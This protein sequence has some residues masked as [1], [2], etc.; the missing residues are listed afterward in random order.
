[1]PST[2]L[3]TGCS[4]GIGA[5]AVQCFAAHGWNVAA[6]LRKLAQARLDQGSGCVEQFALDVTDQASVD[7]AVAQASERFGRIDVLIN[8]AGYG[9]FGPFETAT[10]ELIRRQFATNVEGVFAV[11]RAVLP[12]MRA[13]GSGVIINIASLTGLVAMPL[14][15]LYA[16]SKF[17]VVGFSESLSHEL[18][19]LGIRVKVFAP[20][21]VNTDFSGRSMVRTFEGDG[22]PYADA[23]ARVMATFAA[24]RASGGAASSPEA[25]GEALYGAATDGSSQVRYVVGADAL[26]VMRARQQLGEEALLAGLRQ[27]FGLAAQAGAGAN[28]A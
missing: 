22:G 5:A 25:L 1:M 23:L 27:R 11:T 4:S 13:Q 26:E 17:A 14:Y 16:A 3:I 6:T 20:G 19:P 24:N 2:V 9:L 7:A 10:P 12:G 28:A 8:N 15:S 21:A 18:A